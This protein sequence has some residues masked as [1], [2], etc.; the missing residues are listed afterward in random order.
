ME[1]YTRLDWTALAETEMG[2]EMVSLGR[3]IDERDKPEGQLEE[4]GGRSEEKSVEAEGKGAQPGISPGQEMMGMLSQVV[5]DLPI[6]TNLGLL[7]MLWMLVSGQLLFS[8]GAIF[9]ALQRLGLPRAAVQRAWAAFAGGSWQIADL[10]E[11]WQSLVEAEGL[12]QEHRIEGY[13]VKS[14]DLTAFWRPEL[15]QCPFKHYEPQAGKAL[16][17]IVFGL[18]TRIGQ[19][20]TQRVPLPVQFVR[21]DENNPEE[22]EL[23]AC[24]LAQIAA[25]LAEDELVVVDAGFKPSQLQAA[26]LNRYVVRLAQNSTARRNELPP[27]QGHGR[28]PEYGLLVR[29]LDRSF[30]DKFIPATA[31]DRQ[32][33]WTEGDLKLQAEFWDNLVRSD[34][35]PGAET[36][37]IVAIYDPRYQD[38]L[39]LASPLQL[40]AQAFREIYRD[41]WPV[42]QIP[43]SAKQMIGAARQFV[44]APE[45]CQRLPELALFAGAILTYVAAK[46]PPIPTGF[47]DR[48][49]KSTPG[50]LRRHLE[51]LPLFSNLPLPARIRQ[52]ASVTDHLPKGILGHRRQPRA[53]P[54]S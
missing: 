50:R 7:H 28:H 1:M 6:G 11:R 19:L 32:T 37:N 20:G 43:L 54:A 3:G 30:K 14:A 26:G 27:Y 41:R 44:H 42:E 29:P 23:V 9:P 5:V 40:S 49:P 17:A 38:P 51:G 39:L 52:K 4:T 25:T 47:W 2:Q 22:S 13:R 10:L 31:P 12:W 36:L 35:K 18:V 34:Q 8:R 53:C 45:S 15:A 33:T 16:P 21:S 24:L 46:L 48:T